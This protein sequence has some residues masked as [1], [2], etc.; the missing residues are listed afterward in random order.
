MVKQEDEK[1]M[2]RGK[3]NSRR[4]PTYASDDIG[5]DVDE[6]FQQSDF[7]KEKE[8]RLRLQAK[9]AKKTRKPTDTDK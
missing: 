2:Y 1:K 6:S 9:A 3:G 5:V 4:S 8:L 7:A